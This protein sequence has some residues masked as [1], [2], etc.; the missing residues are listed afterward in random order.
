VMF[1]LKP[2]SL[3]A[4]LIRPSVV[5]SAALYTSCDERAGRSH[6]IIEFDLTAKQ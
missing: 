4:W 2:K 3:M 6:L 5:I 1:H